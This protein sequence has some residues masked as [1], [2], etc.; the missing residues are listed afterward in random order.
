MSNNNNNNSNAR[1][2]A[3]RDMTA[4]QRFFNLPELVNILCACCSTE[5]VDLLTLASV[6]RSFRAIALPHW[7]RYLDL[8][9]STADSKLNFFIAQPA[10][11]PHI[12]FLRIRNDITERQHEFG[13]NPHTPS[14]RAASR[15]KPHWNE[16]TLLLAMIAAQSSS[17]HRPPAIDITVGITQVGA[18]ENA[19]RPFPRL[20]QRI[21]AL[22]I[23]PDVN[24]DVM[25]DQEQQEYEESWQE[26]WTSLA[27][28]IQRIYAQSRSPSQQSHDGD[29]SNPSGSALGLR[30]FHFGHTDLEAEDYD[31][32]PPAVPLEF[33]EEFSAATT[34]SLRDLSLTLARS[35]LPEDIFPLLA[36]SH[37]SNFVLKRSASG[38]IDSLE[39]F[40][41][42]NQSTLEDL[43]LNIGDPAEPLSFRQDFPK[44]KYCQIWSEEYVSR[45]TQL[46]VRINFAQRHPQLKGTAHRVISSDVPS[47]P[48]GIY[49]NLRVL[50]SID[51]AF[52][53]HA[54]QGGRLSHLR[55]ALNLE[56]LATHSWLARN[57]DAA[58]AITCLELF[59]RR[60]TL[61]ED[62]QPHFRSAFSSDFLPNLT[63]LSIGYVNSGG[64]SI[65]DSSEV[66]V[67]GDPLPERQLVRIFADLCPATSLRVLH[68]S[69]SCAVPFQDTGDLLAN[70]PHARFPSSLEYFSWFIP[71]LNETHYYRFVPSSEEQG[72]QPDEG[73]RGRLQRI[74][75]MFRTRITR[76]GVW[77]RPFDVERR[78]VIYDHVPLEGPVMLLS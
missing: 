10:L 22:R 40:L 21:V 1:R 20:H 41:D 19:L 30:V 51:M 39:D 9:L 8:A 38:T 52:E 77:D 59:Y 3:G 17:L 35:D 60:D 44:L 34:S 71:G 15:S 65:F 2:V 5:R 12:R 64:T 23:L 32:S 62:L 63:E 68:L 76:E 55:T 11:L 37:L 74:S 7:A 53:E 75:S 29:S 50:G 42:Q 48:R 26:N 46:E 70:V 49:P 4:T 31:W 47:F 61:A 54:L 14:R 45:S 78:K 57:P 13:F 24:T 69:D 16:M 33:W 6:S 73:K 67:F 43:H 27:R 28:F 56:E 36:H 18:L 66:R 72:T 25:A 58:K